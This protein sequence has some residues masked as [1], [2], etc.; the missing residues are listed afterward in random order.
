M[1]FI[2]PPPL[3]TGDR[4]AVIA[5]SSGA[6]AFFPLLRARGVQRLKDRFKVEP[7]LYPTMFQTSADVHARAKDINDA[8]KDNSIKGIICS[9]GGDDLIRILPFVDRKAICAHPKRVMGYSDI[10]SLHLLLYQCGIVSY[11]GGNLL[12]QFAISGNQMEEFTASSIEKALFSPSSAPAV[13]LTASA[14]FSDGFYEWSNEELQKRPPAN[15]PNA[16]WIWYDWKDGEQ[17]KA[18][19]VTGRLWGGCLSTLY[20]HFVVQ[21][22]LPSFQDFDGN[23]LFLETSETMPSSNT[24]YSFL[25][26]LGEINVLQKFCA[27]LVGRPQTKDR[28]IEPP[29]GRNRYKVEQ[30]EAVVRAVTEYCNS[31]KLPVVVFNIDFGH[32]NPQIIVP[33]GGRCHINTKDRTIEF[34][35]AS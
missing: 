1:T 10:T 35:Y 21:Q 32:T 18:I 30:Q 4:V 24:V 26:A 22:Y 17:P 12:T 31:K 29:I 7:V 13:S 19:N 11:Y 9:I 16:G 5:C 15:E 23:V 27:I 3:Q 25:S 33:S 20:T 2:T 34:Q 6:A 28:E 8:F 14:H